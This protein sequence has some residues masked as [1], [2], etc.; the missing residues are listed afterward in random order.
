M[1]EVNEAPNEDASETAQQYDQRG[2]PINP[3]TK[4]INRDIIRSHN[5]VMLVI[6]VAE[7]ENPAPVPDGQAQQQE[8]DNYEDSAGLALISMAGRC[9]ETVGVFGIHG[10]RQRILIYKRY[11]AIPFWDLYR[12]ARNDFSFS[13]DVLPGVTTSLLANYVERNISTLWQDR[14]DRLIAR[15]L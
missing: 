9:I 15:Q 4:R 6:G 1:V 10:F 7:P 13:R 12:Q 11:S 14:M 5:E 8:H 2:R 3:N